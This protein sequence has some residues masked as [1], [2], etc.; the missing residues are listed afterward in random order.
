[1]PMKFFPTTATLCLY[2][3]LR[4]LRQERTYYGFLPPHGR[5]LDPC[6]IAIIPGDMMSEFKQQTRNDRKRRSFEAALDD[7]S[8]AIVTEPAVH[9]HDTV[10]DE[11]KIAR[12]VDGAV[13]LADPCWGAYAA[14]SSSQCLPVNWEAPV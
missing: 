13:A 1:M 4:N 3:V 11:T 7:G 14:G 6:E 8:I 9:L 12:L 5:R 2:T 10:R